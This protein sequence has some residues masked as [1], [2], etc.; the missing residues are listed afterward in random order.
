MKKNFWN[1]II[2]VFSTKIFIY[3]FTFFTSIYIAR[4]L[5]PEEKGKLDVAI[6]MI[7]VGVQF[8]NL[9]MHSS[10]S[11]YISRDQ[12]NIYKA[13]GNVHVLLSILILLILGISIWSHGD[14]ISRV[15]L[16]M[17]PIQLLV[18]LYENI[19]IAS[20]KIKCYNF[21]EI[22]G[23]LFYPIIIIILSFF[24]KLKAQ[25]AFSVL[26]VGYITIC[27][28]SIFFVY[29]ITKGKVV[30][31]LHFF[32]QSIKYGLKS[33]VACLFSYLVLKADILMINYMRGSRDTGVY[34]LAVSLSDVL[35][36][37][38]SSV[39]LVAFPELSRLPCLS[40][41]R[42]LL[43][44]IFK[45]INLVML[46]LIVLASLAIIPIIK[47]GYGEMYL[48]SIK[49]FWI[50]LPG[51]WAMSNVTILNNFF[52]SINKI[53]VSIIASM[54]GFVGNIAFNII[55]IERFGIIG[56]AL[57]ST[58]SYFIILFILIIY[59]KKNV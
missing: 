48:E 7:S 36:M 53:E 56:A 16:W 12:K 4:L 50:L 24:I 28:L 55:W 15:A 54:L 41:K 52:A 17:I 21:L 18:L 29:R 9:G 11:Y 42:K 22:I 38:S 20:G 34:S 3:I 25:E 10:N 43:K 44:D 51:V 23:N 33:Y 40:D 45:K 35:Y 6:T 46:I 49:A 32:R 30:Y 5:G 13:C 27:I 2:Q 57:S 58:C 31:E 8:G 47:I 59:H 19:L 39:G 26:I 1:N 37:V 14:L